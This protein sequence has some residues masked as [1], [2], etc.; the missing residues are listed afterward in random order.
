MSSRSLSKRCATLALAALLFLSAGCGASRSD[1]VA[2]DGDASASN[3]SVEIGLPA[4]DD[5]LSFAP[6]APQGELRLESFGQGGIHVLLAIRC[7][8][9]GHRA[10]VSITVT[11]LVTGAQVVSPAPPS[12]QLLLCRDAE[13]CDLVPV[14]VMVGAIAPPD[15]ERNSLH[16]RVTA[17][18]HN[19]DGAASSASQ[20]GVLSTVDL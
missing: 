1:G 17:D 6:L 10:F 3:V 18:V 8:G 12:P 19:S 5:G 11:N 13:V 4:G 14:L 7:I 9:F 2:V 20:E 16:V 15:S